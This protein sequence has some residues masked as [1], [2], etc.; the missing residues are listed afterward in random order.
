[1]KIRIGSSLYSIVNLK[2]PGGSVIRTLA[3]NEETRIDATNAFHAIHSR[4][5]K[6]LKVLSALPSTPLKES[7]TVPVE[8]DWNSLRMQLEKEGWFRPSGI[9][10]IYRIAMNAFLWWLASY[11]FAMGWCSFAI[12][13]MSVNYVQ[14]GWI[15]HECGHK[16]FT[17]DSMWDPILQTVYLNLFMGGNRRF[18][19]DQHFSHHA[20]TQNII[21]D[22]DL[23]THPLV[24][25]DKKLV[26]RKGHTWF[27]KRQ[28]WMYWWVVNPLVWMVWSFVS[29]P[30]FAYTKQHFWEYAATKFTSLTLYCLYFMFACGVDTVTNSM[31]LFHLVSLIGTCLLLATFTVSHTTTGAYESYQGWVIPASRHTVNIHDH[32]LTNWWMGYLNFQIEHHLF[33]TMPQFRQNRVGKQYVKPFFAKHSIPYT[34]TS[35]WKANVDVYRNLQ[36]ISKVEQT[37]KDST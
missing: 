13:L 32:W 17:G 16:S 24:A 1:M 37:T 35:F 10:V 9:H 36:T 7:T 18:W 28:H 5:R 20:N 25:F 21:H 26:E 2:H 14:C 29:H 6:A 33:P 4:S 34:E 8:V 30:M 23:K 22:K 19:N 31:F 27:T 12:L 15:Q 3:W 11:L